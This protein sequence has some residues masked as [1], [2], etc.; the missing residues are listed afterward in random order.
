MAIE[1][2]SGS[3]IQVEVT[4]TGQ[5]PVS[6]AIPAARG[7]IGP[8]GPTGPQGEVGETGPKGTT[9]AQGAQG[10]KGTT[11]TGGALGSYGSFYD[12]T[13]QS[14]SVVNTGQAV[15]LNSEFGSNDISIV[16]GSKITIAS[17]GTYQ[18]TAVLQLSNPDNNSS[19]SA[20][21]WLKFNGSDY[22]NSGTEVLMQAAKNASIPNYQLVTITFIG[23]STSVN[24]YVQIFWEADSIDLSLEYTAAD[25]TH[26]AVPSA[27]VSVQQVMY[28][29][30]GPTGPRGET[31]PQGEQGPKGQTGEKGDTGDTGPQGL[32]G[33]QGPQG[34]RGETG[35]KGE[36]GPKG[37]TGEKGDT[38]DIGPQGPQGPQGDTGPQGERGPT[39]LTGT[40]GVD[41][42][43][44]VGVPAGG[45]A[46]Y[47]LAKATNNDYDTEWIVAPSGGTG[48]GISA[49]VED[50]SPQLGG[51]LETNGYSILFPEAV[52]GTTGAKISS[53]ASSGGIEITTYFPGSDVIIT[54]KDD[55]I[56][57][58]GDDVDINAT[59]SI[60]LDSGNGPDKISLSGGSIE[61][62]SYSG[63]T[64]K[65]EGFTYPKTDGS[66]G[67]VLVTN[68]NKVLSFQSV[69][70]VAG[71]TGPTGLSA[72][73]VWIFEG[74]S[75][76]TSVYL[77]S[78]IGEQ[79]PQGIQGI[80]GPQG[81]QGIQ[82][83]QGPQ[84]IQGIQGERGPTGTTGL[85]GD[86]GDTGPQGIQ[87]IQGQT[88]PQG[89]QGIQGVQGEQGIQGEQ[90]PQGER[91]PTGL[92]GVKGDTGDTGL[93]GPQGIQGEQGIQGPQGI[94]GEQG[95][96]GQ[97]GATGATGATYF[98]VGS[99]TTTTYTLALADAFSYLV[100][101]NASAITI[102]V[103]AQSSVSWPDDT[104]II[105]EQ[106][107]AGT[108]GLTAASGVTLYS[109]Q[110]LNS[111]G[112][113]AVVGLKRT[114][115][116]TWVLTGERE[117]S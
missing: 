73:E 108:V 33:P 117:A 107:G 28:T 111:A 69:S 31:G 36:T 66:S 50:L 99:V 76:T 103:P 89:I 90:G 56:L 55:F 65:I 1:V 62:S 112:Q 93:Q 13:D 98:T 10:P 34:L 37:Q 92:T 67:D 53:S 52:F 71:A 29:Q 11:G 58:S 116:D 20:F 46:G 41:G 94:Q 17:P 97:T 15:L 23:T 24:D 5:T 83:E 26:P 48:G 19:H 70:G 2:K 18:L 54:A 6:V 8:T 35:L 72:Y 110:T 9:G 61:I 45:T 68:G 7:S 101:N 96:Q 3:T 30:L 39:G 78:L 16:D 86:T 21:F 42:A 113:Y 88:G 47:I 49:I 59:G 80:Q 81:E 60:L 114:A 84:G 4:T 40:P 102:T 57:N 12:T 82:G 87:G 44:G 25:A 95:P 105:I 79:G 51:D 22:P 106:R 74:N 115:S 63:L 91:G 14:I 75:G 43:T 104:E 27:I 77:A 85:K 38:G 100:A 109:S 32:E 64:T